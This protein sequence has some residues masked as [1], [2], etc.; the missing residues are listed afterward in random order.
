MKLGLDLVFVDVDEDSAHPENYTDFFLFNAKLM[1]EDGSG[2]VLPK[3][4]S[5][6]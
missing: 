4:V 6:E 5:E 1:R 2:G 3:L